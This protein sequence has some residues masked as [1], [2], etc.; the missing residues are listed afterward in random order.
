MMSSMQPGTMHLVGLVVDS[1]P[2]VGK[3]ATLVGEGGFGTGV[4]GLDMV[5]LGNEGC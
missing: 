4:V 3:L 5:G 1:Q 2:S